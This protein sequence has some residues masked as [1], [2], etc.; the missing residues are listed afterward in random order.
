MTPPSAFYALDGFLFLLCWPNQ[1][2]A[3]A[4]AIFDH[5]VGDVNRRDDQY[6]I[7]VGLAY[8]PA[9]C[10]LNPSRFAYYARRE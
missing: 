5:F 10:R 1:A 4:E 7:C 6:G 3:D 2:A 8:A 9:R